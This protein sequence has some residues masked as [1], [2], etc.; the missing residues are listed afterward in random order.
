MTI[1]SP[2]CTVFVWIFIVSGCR[3]CISSSFITLDLGPTFTFLTAGAGVSGVFDSV[4]PFKIV[5][6]L[7]DAAHLSPLP[8]VLGFA[9]CSFRS[10][11]LPK[12][13][14]LIVNLDWLIQTFWNHL[15]RLIIKKK[16]VSTKW[17][18]IVK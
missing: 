1:F 3:D 12:T 13:C 6:S 7:F 16:H 17:V 11:S 14:P 18:I 2:G 4:F 15:I 10:T 5:C 9:A 8:F